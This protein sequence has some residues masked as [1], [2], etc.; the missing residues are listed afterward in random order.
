MKLFGKKTLAL[1]L[2]LA[3]VMP[4][5]AFATETT[6]TPVAVTGVSLNTTV[7]PLAKGGEVTLTAT[8]TPDNATDKTVV[9][10]SSDTAIATVDASGLVKAIAPGTAV[11]TAKAGDKSATCTLTV[12]KKVIPVSGISL[13]HTSAT[14]VEG[15]SLTLTAT[16]TPA[17]ATD[18]TV[19]WSGSNT[20]VAT[21]DA[22]GVV[23]A[24]AP[25]AAVITAQAGGFTATCEIIVSVI[26]S[27]EDLKA[28]GNDAVVYDLK[29]R[30][31]FD[32]DNLKP[33]LYIVNGKRVLI[34][35]RVN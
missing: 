19:T 2:A 11:I 15:E 34:G 35:K 30:R 13:N 25:G 26:D 7:A 17:D 20:A 18:K 33:G 10:S 4:M 24:I 27:I 23:K 32:V 5:C 14:L 8:V 1:F 16:V 3:M 6:P 31:I 22:N 9:W 28:L 29:G 21:V 12:E